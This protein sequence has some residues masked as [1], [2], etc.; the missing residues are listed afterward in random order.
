MFWQSSMH[1]LSFLLQLKQIKVTANAIFFKE[2]FHKCGFSKIVQIPLS[3]SGKC[4]LRLSHDVISHIMNMVKWSSS[5][6]RTGLQ[7]LGALHLART[8]CLLLDK[9][10]I[11]FEFVSP[12]ISGSRVDGLW[13]W[14]FSSDKPTSAAQCPMIYRGYNRLYLIST[15]RLSSLL[16]YYQYIIFIIIFSYL[17]TWYWWCYFSS[18]KFIEYFANISPPLFPT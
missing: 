13:A 10:N 8:I 7:G 17:F 2:Y 14:L 6:P 5:R 12:C 3:R 1:Q 9:D 18:C 16:H 4:N 15:H 11:W